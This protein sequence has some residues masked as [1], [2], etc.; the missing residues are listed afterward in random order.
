MTVRFVLTGLFVCSSIGFA[1]APDPC[2]Q[3]P[4]TCATLIETHATS[5]M[6][7]P[8]T[9]VD[10]SV[11]V[12][13]SGK[14]L[15]EVQRAL[16]DQ[17]NKLLAYLKAQ[18]VERLITTQVRFKPDTKYEKSGPNKT[19]GYDGSAKVSFRAKPDK[20][21]D[22]L[23]GV[24]ANGADEIQSTTFTPTEE[25]IAAARRKLSEDA[26]KTAI[27]RADTVATAAGLKVT[28]IRNINVDS[29]NSSGL[30]SLSAGVLANQFTANAVG[31]A[32][33]DAASGDSQLSI[34][35]NVTAAA[36]R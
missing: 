34:R 7:I 3:A 8:N 22:L 19:V 13:A 1:Q 12:S 33:V 10:V 26:T 24:L 23:A 14:D 17:S 31:P 35:V 27:E 4:Q 25:E 11:G 36:T 2:A 32:A 21:P 15:P 9:V 30:V 29:D 28:A 5:E 18:Q 16:A 20:V 6:R